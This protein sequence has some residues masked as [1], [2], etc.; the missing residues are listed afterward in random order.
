MG[1]LVLRKVRELKN[2]LTAQGIINDKLESRILEMQEMQEKALIELLYD[3]IESGRINEEM[4]VQELINR[5]KVYWEC[6]I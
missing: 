1:D 3:F 2:K 4:T 5:F 6:K